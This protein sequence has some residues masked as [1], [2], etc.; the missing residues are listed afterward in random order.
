MKNKNMLKNNGLNI[1]KSHKCITP[2]QLQ[3]IFLSIAR[4]VA[5]G[6]LESCRKEESSDFYANRPDAFNED[7]FALFDEFS[8]WKREIK[9]GYLLRIL[10]YVGAYDGSKI[11]KDRLL[12][13]LRVI[14]FIARYS[15]DRNGYALSF[16]KGALE[17]PYDD[18]ARLER[19]V[20]TAV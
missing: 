16:K 14:C 18:V 9:E 17:V 5:D 10:K 8:Q 13:A 20:R 12:T 15:D 1:K 19:F 7:F 2:E 4:K 6:F 3:E 11:D